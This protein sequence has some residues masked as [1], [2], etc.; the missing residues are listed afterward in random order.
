MEVAHK[1]LDAV[2]VLQ[3]KVQGDQALVG[4]TYRPMVAPVSQDIVSAGV[5]V[6]HVAAGHDDNSSLLLKIQLLQIMN[7]YV[8]GLSAPTI[9]VQ[10]RVS[11]T[12]PPN[13]LCCMLH[14]CSSYPKWRHCLSLHSML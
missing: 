6:M 11:L 4:F 3:I 2:E 10:E 13:A 14:M 1:L 5:S 12:C 9:S 7:E 8:I